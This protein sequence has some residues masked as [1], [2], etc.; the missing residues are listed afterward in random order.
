MLGEADSGPVSDLFDAIAA[1]DVPA[2][3]ALLARQPEA[4][5]AR[6]PDGV[7]ALMQ[8]IYRGDDDMVEAIRAS[9]P[10]LDVFEAAA[11]G[12]AEMISGDV[13]VV[14]PD[15]FTPLHFAVMSGRVEAVRAVLRLGADPNA[16]SEHRFIKVR[17]LHT[18]TAGEISPAK[19]EVVRALLDA[20]ADPNGRTG[21]GGATPLHNAAESGSRE[22]IAVLLEHGADAKLA[23]DDGR[24]PAE[25]AATEEL[26]T[27]LRA[28]PV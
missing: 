18:A 11:L 26:A 15:G 17:P 27:V 21:E 8:A 14:S 10:P 22:L 24:T 1:G 25:L 12:E 5:G 3:Q 28:A 2:V 4:S 16:L 23:L 19:P 9:A 13:D 20:G 7:S 6:D